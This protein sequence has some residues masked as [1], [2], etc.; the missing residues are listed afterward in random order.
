[1]LTSK[2]AGDDRVRWRELPI[3]AVSCHV[4]SSHDED[5]RIIPCPT[6]ASRRAPLAQTATPP[7]CNDASSRSRRSLSRNGASSAGGRSPRGRRFTTT[8]HSYDEPSLDPKA[9]SLTRHHLQSRTG[10]APDAAAAAATAAAASAAAN[11]SLWRTRVSDNDDATMA[12]DG[13]DSARV[14]G[15]E[16]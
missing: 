14:R 3:A 8:P 9:G 7:P 13:D 4:R 11:R 6:L 15:V 16:W 1:M 10:L 12:R 5:G 2:E